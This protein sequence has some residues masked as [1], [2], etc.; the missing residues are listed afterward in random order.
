LLYVALERQLGAIAPL[1]YSCS[2]AVLAGPPLSIAGSGFE[3]AKKLK[4]AALES[5]GDRLVHVRLDQRKQGIIAHATINNARHLNAMNSALMEAFV[6]AMAQLATDE[7]LRAVVLTGAGRKAFIAGADINEMAAIESAAQAT[8][9]ITRLHRCCDAIRDLPVPVIARIQ[10]FT[11]GAGLEIAAACDVRIAADAALFGMPEVKL[12]IPSV[13]EAALLPMLVGWGRAREIMLL[14]ETFTA[15]EA[16]EWG[17]V[18]RV[19]PAAA[20]DEAIEAWIGRLLTSMPRAVRLQKRL[21][22]QW[23][24]LP[25]AAAIQAGIEAFARAYETDEPAVATREFLA[26]QKARKKTS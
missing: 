11:F 13:I 12:G 23:E 20:L 15:N 1:R 2:V 18:E 21:I 17:L 14:G 5:S 16:L 26:T 6:D 24:G 19:V 22:R 10:G 3:Q 4:E 9:F 7:R 25:L 8:V